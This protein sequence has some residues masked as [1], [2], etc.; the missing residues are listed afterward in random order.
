MIEIIITAYIMKVIVAALD[1]P[2]LYIAKWMSNKY[3]IDKEVA[4]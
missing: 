4:V 2:F 1:T 3:N